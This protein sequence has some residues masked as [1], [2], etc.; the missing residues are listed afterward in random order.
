[1]EDDLKKNW[2]R[3]KKKWEKN[4]DDQKNKKIKME[5]VLKKKRKTNQSTKINLIGCDPIVHSPSISHSEAHR[6]TWWHV[7]CIDCLF[8]ELRPTTALSRIIDNA[9]YDILTGLQKLY[10][11]ELSFDGEHK[12]VEIIDDVTLDPVAHAI[13]DNTQTSLNFWPQNTW[14]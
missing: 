10:L 13:S 5:N 9:M 14:I 1:M 2:R 3:P 8:P 12:T 11:W 6:N 4:E 7:Y